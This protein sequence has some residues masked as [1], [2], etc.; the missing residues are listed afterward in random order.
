MNDEA[1]YKT[2]NEISLKQSDVGD[3][4]NFIQDGKSV[5]FCF[6]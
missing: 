3:E 1:W 4:G 5:L 2:K 6:K